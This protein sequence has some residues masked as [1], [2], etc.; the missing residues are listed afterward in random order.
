M[1]RW[2]PVGLQCEVVC[3]NGLSHRTSD[4]SSLLHTG[5][6]WLL[7]FARRSQAQ[8]PMLS[9]PVRASTMTKA[10][11]AHAQWPSVCYNNTKAVVLP[12]ITDVTWAHGPT[13]DLG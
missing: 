11:H 3:C 10:E 13:A 5:H 12:D 4:G 8:C 1:V 7:L 6:M 9:S 2:V